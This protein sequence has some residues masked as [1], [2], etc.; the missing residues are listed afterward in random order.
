MGTNLMAG[1]LLSDSGSSSHSASLVRLFRSDRFFYAPEQ[2][3][4][5]YSASA[6]QPLSPSPIIRVGQAPGAQCFSIRRSSPLLK[7]SV[8]KGFSSQVLKEC[9]IIVDSNCSC[10][11]S[12]IRLDQL[13][14]RYGQPTVPC[15]PKCAVAMKVSCR[16]T[17]RMSGRASSRSGACASRRELHALLC[18]C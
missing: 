6:W 3:R 8:L 5:I 15:R 4:Q 14:L 16:S 12:A 17:F 18:R 13:V 9:Q 7:M 11:S 2:A 10:P 1:T